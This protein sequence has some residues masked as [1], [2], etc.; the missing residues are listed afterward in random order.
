M[1]SYQLKLERCAAGKD[2]EY[3]RHL[4]FTLLTSLGLHGR[5]MT[6]FEFYPLGLAVAVV[7]EESHATMHTW[8]EMSEIQLDIF[9]CGELVD[10]FEE[11][12]IDQVNQLFLP[13]NITGVVVD[14]NT[15]EIITAF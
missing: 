3:V 15:M 8:P 14:R 7:L 12:L 1:M 5:T 2:R 13:G 6:E 9:H 11:V 4:F 10:D